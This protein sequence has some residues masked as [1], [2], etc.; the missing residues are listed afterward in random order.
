MKIIWQRTW[1]HCGINYHVFSLGSCWKCL[2]KCKGII[3]SSG[4]VSGEGLQTT[5]TMPQRLTLRQTLWCNESRRI[6]LAL[7]ENKIKWMRENSWFDR[8]SAQC[9]CHYIYGQLRAFEHFTGS[10][11]SRW[12]RIRKAPR[13]IIHPYLF[14]S[15]TFV[16]F[17]LIAHRFVIRCTVMR[18]HLIAVYSEQ[19]GLSDGV[20]EKSLVYNF[21]LDNCILLQS[22]FSVLLKAR[23]ETTIC[24]H[25]GKCA[26]NRYS[27]TIRLWALS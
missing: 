24:I 3:V 6:I 19:S 26:S 2:D 25:D 12:A 18:L 15:W 7:G 11:C 27:I 23:H 16:D 8:L 13:A 17:S 14:C 9:C 1:L 4:F 5:M 21:D 20:P 10:L 22:P